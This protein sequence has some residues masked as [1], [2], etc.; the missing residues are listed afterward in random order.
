MASRRMRSLVNRRTAAA[1]RL[2]AEGFTDLT[3]IAERTGFGSRSSL[4]RAL[5][6]GAAIGGQPPRRR[7]AAL[8]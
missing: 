6:G 5:T 7:G 2:L 4:Y 8:N 1:Q 3:L